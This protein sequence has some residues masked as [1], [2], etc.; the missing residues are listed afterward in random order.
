MDSISHPKPR[1]KAQ[2]NVRGGEFTPRES[3]SEI[4]KSFLWVLHDGPSIS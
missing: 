3:L 4:L 1:L 2:L